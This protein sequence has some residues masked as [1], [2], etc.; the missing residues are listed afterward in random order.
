VIEELFLDQNALNLTITGV[1]N[2][3]ITI[4]EIEYVIKLK[5]YFILQWSH[6]LSM[7]LK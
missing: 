7:S 5:T 1:V 4:K 2:S 6:K 3:T